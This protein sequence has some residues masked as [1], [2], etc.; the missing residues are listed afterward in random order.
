M[1]SVSPE[2]ILETKPKMDSQL[3][4]SSTH[5]SPH[6]GTDLAFHSSIRPMSEILSITDNQSGF[7]MT[8][9]EDPLHNF[10]QERI[11]EQHPTTYNSNRSC[12]A[13]VLNTA[14]QGEQAMAAV[15]SATGIETHGRGQKARTGPIRNVK[16][17]IV[18]ASPS[19]RSNLQSTGNL[20]KT[21]NL[22]SMKD[23][24]NTWNLRSTG[25]LQ[26][27]VGDL[28]GTA[29]LESTANLQSM[30]N[31]QRTANLESTGNLHSKGNLQRIGNLQC[32][33]NLQS[34]ENLQRTGNVQSMGTGTLENTGNLQSNR[35]VQSNRNLQSTG[36]VSS[37]TTIQSCTDIAP[38]THD[39]HPASNTA[40]QNVTSKEYSEPEQQFAGIRLK[41]FQLPTLQPM[42]V[43]VPSSPLIPVGFPVMKNKRKRYT[44]FRSIFSHKTNQESDDDV[45]PSE[46]K[47][48][49][50]YE[51]QDGL[52]DRNYIF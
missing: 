8:E 23:I 52:G 48:S 37:T 32:M 17:K 7:K 33:K 16:V 31:L 3:T 13:S 44:P 26:S 20:Q 15:N 2:N 22:Q 21:G 14:D 28:Q 6:L 1:E 9:L 50:P 12:S 45:W 43:P 30:G 36:S 34:T 49:K 38:K 39:S 29:N 51:P 24:Q 35:N 19:Q 10:R 41:Q 4:T 27:T 42:P 25:N 18:H 40:E 11:Q 47:R 5:S 46:H